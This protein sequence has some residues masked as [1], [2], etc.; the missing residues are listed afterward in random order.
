MTR[1]CGR[2]RR[3]KRLCCRVPHGHWK[4]TTFIAALRHDGLT[5]PLLVDGPINKDLFVA[6]VEQQLTPTL[7]PGDVVIMDNLSAH[8]TA[9]VRTAIEA[10]GARL[11]YLPA[12]SPDLNPIEQAFSKLKAHLRKA[13]KRT[14][15]EL[16]Q[17]ISRC[18]DTYTPTECQNYFRHTGYQLRN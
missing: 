12:Y 10:V 14:I 16:E 1:R 17:E 15:S 2:A 18:I 7:R 9:P 8:H 5:A 6:Y 4:T 13:G 11:Q 3:G